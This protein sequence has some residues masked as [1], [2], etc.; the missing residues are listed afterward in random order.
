MRRNLGFLQCCRKG[1]Q[2]VNEK[3]KVCY[4]LSELLSISDCPSGATFQSHLGNWTSSVGDF[5]VMK[6]LLNEAVR[7][8]TVEWPR[9]SGRWSSK[10]V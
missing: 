1:F 6:L 3:P 7:F 9:R 5:K 2:T 4:E 10:N 8:C